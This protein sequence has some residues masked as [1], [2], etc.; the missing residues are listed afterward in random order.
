MAKTTL[1]SN[2]NEWLHMTIYGYI[3]G[4]IDDNYELMTR[5]GWLN[6]LMICLDMDAKSNQMVN[7]LEFKHI[8]FYG[9]ENIKK[10][11]IEFLKRDD[12]KKYVLD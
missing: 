8:Y 4:I 9:K 1:K 6:Y 3:N 7:G 2:V 12:V 11:A 10:L 5:D